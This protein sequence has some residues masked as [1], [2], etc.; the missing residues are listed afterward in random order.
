[1]KPTNGVCKF[2]TISLSSE[3]KASEVLLVG[4][5]SFQAKVSN[6]TASYA[7]EATEPRYDVMMD[8]KSVMFRAGK[9]SCVFFSISPRN[10]LSVKF[11]FLNEEGNYSSVLV[12]LYRF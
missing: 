9:S 7:I 8:W 12:I 6:Q 3:L 5:T 4:P 11:S 2:H 1:M 10:S